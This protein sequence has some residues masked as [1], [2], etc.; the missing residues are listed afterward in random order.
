MEKPTWTPLFGKLTLFGWETLNHIDAGKKCSSLN[1]KLFKPKSQDQI[2]ALAK[3]M[4]QN[5]NGNMN[6]YKK[7]RVIYKAIRWFP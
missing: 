7:N 2:F 1:G 6:R 4:L 3:K 5:T